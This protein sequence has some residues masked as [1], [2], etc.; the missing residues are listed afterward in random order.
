MLGLH[1]KKVLPS[2]YI[3]I[4][5]GRAVLKCLFTSK[6]FYRTFLKLFAS[7]LDNYS[8]DFSEYFFINIDLITETVLYS[9]LF[10]C[11]F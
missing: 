5:K 1:I 4:I 11:I 7:L 8:G 10:A 6:V 9:S 3:Q 2:K